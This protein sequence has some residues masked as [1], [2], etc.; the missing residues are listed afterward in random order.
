MQSALL[1]QQLLCRLDSQ[2]F[3]DFAKN[4]LEVEFKHRFLRFSEIK[5]LMRLV[6]VQRDRVYLTNEA[7]KSSTKSGK[8]THGRLRP[9]S[10]E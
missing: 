5:A 7:Q 10:I 9:R 4:C 8:V 6:Y 2:L 3:T 1:H